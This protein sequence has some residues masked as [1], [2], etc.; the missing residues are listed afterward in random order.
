MF[1][2]GEWL[3]GS[4]S[5]FYPNCFFEL[6]LLNTP[7]IKPSEKRLNLIHGVLRNFGNVFDVMG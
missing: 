7:T 5:Q 1:C 6:L 3:R 4:L 2:L